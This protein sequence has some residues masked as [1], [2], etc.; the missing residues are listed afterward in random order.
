MTAEL[1]KEAS[2]PREDGELSVKLHSG[3]FRLVLHGQQGRMTFIGGDRRKYRIQAGRYQ[4]DIVLQTPSEEIVFRTGTVNIAPNRTVSITPPFGSSFRR[5]DAPQPEPKDE[6]PGQSEVWDLAVSPDGRTFVTATADGTVHASKWKETRNGETTPLKYHG[7]VLRK[8]VFSP[9]GDRIAVGSMDGTISICDTADYRLLTA[10]EAHEEGV[11]G[12]AFSPDG[13]TLA[14]GGPHDPRMKLWD[15][16]TGE[17][18]SEFDAHQELVYKIAFSAD[19]SLA[20]TSGGSDGALTVWDALT[21]KKRFSVTASSGDLAD[22]A[23]SADGR[24]VATAGRDGGARLWDATNGKLINTFWHND[25]LNDVAFLE[26]EGTLFA[27]GNDGVVPGWDLDSGEMK[28]CFCAHWGPVRSIAVTPDGSSLI[29]GSLDHTTRMWNISEL[30]ETSPVAGPSPESTFFMSAGHPAID[31]E[32]SPSGSLLATRAS[33]GQTKVWDL[34]TGR[35]QHDLGVL[36]GPLFGMAFSPDSKTLIVSIAGKNI[37]CFDTDTFKSTA[38]SIGGKP[39]CIALTP[40]GGKAVVVHSFDERVELWDKNFTER[41]WSAELQH[42]S[43]SNP[44]VSPDG[45]TI[46][47]GAVRAVPLLDTATGKPKSKP[48]VHGKGGA[49]ATAFSPDGESLATGG[50]DK[51]VRIWRVSD[52]SQIHVLEGHIGEVMS[53]HFS[54]DGKLLVTADVSDMM[55]YLRVEIP[56]HAGKIIVWDVETG[57][58]LVDF[59]VHNGAVIA[60]EFSPNGKKIASTGRDGRVHIWDVGKLLEYGAKTAKDE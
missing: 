37:Q 23:F 49:H 20:A 59:T 54:P 3:S 7:D 19:G 39:Y 17:L 52:L 35:L 4:A 30:P 47:L 13:K 14:S 29:T 22:L 58:S 10:I 36:W 42:G 53:V 44:S 56:Q 21:W 11:Y 25:A 38:H 46:L 18:I 40:D 6:L 34:K 41:Y 50:G 15:P 32:F 51:L 27:A 24:Y 48:L 2:S 1:P 45:T 60:A 31:L 5:H 28:C 8:I 55:E 33:R 26:A 57:E 9:Q 12:L 16:Q 43:L